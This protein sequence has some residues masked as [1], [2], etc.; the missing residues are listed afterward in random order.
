MVDNSP[1]S[2]GR[3][4]EPGH[5]GRGGSGRPSKGLLIAGTVIVVLAVIAAAVVV[6]RSQTGDPSPR[7]FA[8]TS[9]TAVTLSST[10]TDA[11]SNT[12]PPVITTTS[13]TSS[14]P[15]STLP[16]DG[17]EAFL[18]QG[19]ILLQVGKLQEA[20]RAY[21]EELVTD[22]GNSSVRG[23]LGIAYLL[24]GDMKRLAEQELQTAIDADPDNV[25]AM[26]FL[27]SA[28]FTD[29]YTRGS[30]DYDGAEQILQAALQ[31]DPLNWRAHGFIA[32]VY[33]EQGRP[34]E[35]LAAALRAVELAPDD[36]W[37]QKSLGFVRALRGEWSDAVGP[38]RKAVELQ[39]N[40]A[41]L[42]LHLSEALRHSGQ[43]DE[44][45]DWAE[46][47]LALGQGHEQRAHAFIAHALWLEG[48]LDE[49][50]TGF[51][52]AVGLQADDAY[53]WWGLGAVLYRKGDY[54]EAVTHLEKAAAL[55]PGVALYH[56]WLGACLVNVKRYREA[57]AELERALELDPGDADAQDLL[58]QLKAAG[59]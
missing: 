28:R 30:G 16:L 38:H 15:P 42:Q 46:S 33:V 11:P 20:I 49:A 58:K 53:A 1:S 27:G 13:T 41:F 56:S 37:A 34:D 47:A 26:A 22:P 21:Q 32:E 45:L 25:D 23:K 12:S 3:G 29:V 7:L 19:D 43:H 55:K 35:G 51:R 4:S 6:V 5:V 48:D 50:V 31:K 14:G 59:Y 39:P 54:A 2:G 18:S 24:T 40:Y 57:K 52:N 17:G 10:T 8:S 9:S 44:A 36:F